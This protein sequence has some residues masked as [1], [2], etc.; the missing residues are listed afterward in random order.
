VK[1]EEKLAKEEKPR[2]LKLYKDIAAYFYQDFLKREKM[3]RVLET[4]SSFLYSSQQTQKGKERGGMSEGDA[5]SGGDNYSCG[6]SAEENELL[7]SSRSSSSLPKKI[8]FQNSAP[9]SSRGGGGREEE[10]KRG[11]GKEEGRGEKREERE[12]ESYTNTLD[13]GKR[14]NWWSLRCCDCGTL[15]KF[16]VMYHYSFF[17][18]F[19]SFFFLFWPFFF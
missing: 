5:I 1:Q 11:E 19:F 13:M 16:V 7:K 3:E 6:R 2:F 8:S 4:T 12:G 9:S 18:F 15:L 10:E 17:F 14:T